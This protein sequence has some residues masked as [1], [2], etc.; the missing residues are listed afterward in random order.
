VPL[1]PHEFTH[2]PRGLNW[3]GRITNYCFMLPSSGNVPTEIRKNHWSCSASDGYGHTTISV[4]TGICV[5]K[6]SVLAW[7][8]E[9]YNPR[10]LFRNRGKITVPESIWLLI[11]CFFCF[12]Q[13]MGLV[14]LTPW[15][16]YPEHLLSES[17]IYVHKKVF[18][19]LEGK[20]SVKTLLQWY[21]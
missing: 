1:P 7:K 18:C 8:K 15:P 19:I 6:I 12:T 10:K 13:V 21:V 4:V 9:Y 14:A 2:P 11:K 20:L 17:R 3:L 16:K 5:T